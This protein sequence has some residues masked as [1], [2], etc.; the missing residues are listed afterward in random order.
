M[1]PCT[2]PLFSFFSPPS[3]PLLSPLSYIP[4]PTHPPLPTLLFL[5]FTRTPTTPSL[6]CPFSHSDANRHHIHQLH[7]F[8]SARIDLHHQ[9]ATGDRGLQPPLTAP[10]LLK[11]GKKFQKSSQPHDLIPSQRVP[12]HAIGSSN[13]SV[14]SPAVNSF[15]DSLI[16]GRSKFDRRQLAEVHAGT[17]MQSNAIKCNQMPLW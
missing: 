10:D 2:S 6:A 11:E 14:T 1:L 5:S 17:F 13:G 8:P 15:H 16:L 9:Q 4:Y 7:R 3:S 12:T